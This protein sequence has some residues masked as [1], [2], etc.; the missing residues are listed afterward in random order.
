MGWGLSMCRSLVKVMN[1]AITFDDRPRE[2]TICRIVILL[3][4][5]GDVI[6]VCG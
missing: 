4:R 2:G 5:Y 3:K 6:L 1:G